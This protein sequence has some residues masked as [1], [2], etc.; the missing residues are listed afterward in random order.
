MDQ[1]VRV[2]GIAWLGVEL[3]DVEVVDEEA[4]HFLHVELNTHRPELGVELE[5]IP[6]ALVVVLG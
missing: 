5:V 3:R 6:F 2:G 4:Q 1:A